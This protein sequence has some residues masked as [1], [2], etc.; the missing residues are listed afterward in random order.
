MGLL[1]VVDRSTLTWQLLSSWDQ[2]VLDTI[3]LTK[4]T[5]PAE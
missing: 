5:T 3:T 2:S 4:T 1:Q